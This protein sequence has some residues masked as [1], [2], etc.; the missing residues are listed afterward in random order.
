[1]L[2]EEIPE[3]A[4]S[5][6]GVKSPTPPVSTQ[7]EQVRKNRHRAIETHVGLEYRVTLEERE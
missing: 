2:I 6:L 1:M 5:G 3:G 7:K 4:I